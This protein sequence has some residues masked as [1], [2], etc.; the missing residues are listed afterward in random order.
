MSIPKNLKHKP[1][2]AINDYEKVDAKYAK[3][4]DA[5]YLS[6][7]KAQWSKNYDVLSMKIWR[8]TGK[9]WSRQSEELPIHRTLDLVLLFVGALMHNPKSN[10]NAISLRETVV[11]ETHLSAIAD[12]YK[13]N[14]D[15]LRPRLEEL[16]DK[17]NQFLRK[18]DRK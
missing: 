12:Y 5:K 3:N 1:I 16:S 6:I 10:F 11:D 8:H 7:G 9:K 2:V 13:K 14:E 15:Y 17:I 18:E 4:T